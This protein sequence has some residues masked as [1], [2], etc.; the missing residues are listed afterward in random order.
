MAQLDWNVLFADIL[1]RMPRIE[2]GELVPFT[3]AQMK[4]LF[5]SNL[6]ETLVDVIGEDIKA[7]DTGVI[8]EDLEFL[9]QH[10]KMGFIMRYL[11]NWLDQSEVWIGDLRLFDIFF[12]SG[13]PWTSDIGSFNHIN[14][15]YVI[16]DYIRKHKGECELVAYTVLSDDS[17]FWWSGFDMKLAIECLDYYGYKI[18]ETASYVYS[19]DKIVGFLK[20]L[21]GYVFDA[22]AKVFVGDFQSRYVKLA[23]SEREIEQDL[24]DSTKYKADVIGIYNITGDIEIDSF[25]SKLASFGSEAGAAILEVLRIVKD[26]TLGRSVIKVI[27]GMRDDGQYELY[28]PDVV[29]GFRPDHLAKLP[30]QGLLNPN[31]NTV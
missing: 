4:K 26:T 14:M 10:T 30:I 11:L 19:R 18:K 25:I 24:V 27:M 20:V 28:R 23:H 15:A 1:E 17:L 3:A 31:L 8:R 13:H 5:S 9:T 7:Y 6:G 21:V 12:K 16:R 22:D 2:N 29:A